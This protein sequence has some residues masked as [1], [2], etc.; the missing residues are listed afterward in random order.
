[1]LIIKRYVKRFLMFLYYLMHKKQKKAVFESFSGKSYSDNPRAISEKLHELLP[2]VEI[3]WLFNDPQ[4]KEKIVPS[5]VRCVKRNTKNMIKEY[6]TAK[7][8]VNNFCMHDFIYK[9]HQNYYIQTWHGDRPF[10]KVIFESEKLNFKKSEVREYKTCDLCVSGSSIGEHVYRKAFLYEGDI[11]KVGSPRADVLIDNSKDKIEKIKHNLNI[12][13][14]SKVVMYAPTFRDTN[15]LNT[16]Q[17]LDVLDFKKLIQCLKDKYENE[18]YCLVRVHPS[19]SIKNNVVKEDKILNVSDYEDMSD[20]LLIS[21][22]LITDYSSSAGDFVLKNKPLILY[23]YDLEEY[24]AEDRELHFRMSDSPFWRVSNERELFD[25]IF[26]L[27]EEDVIKNC[28][29]ILSFYGAY[30]SGKAS[31]SVCKCIEDKIK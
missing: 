27:K 5:Y 20:L 26:N 2:E 8:W 31:E 12:P 29:D 22:L 30:E 1:M 28:R 17:N 19:I 4:K 7:I 16:S 10:K 21:D 24:E 15:G 25:F 23:Q 3:V 13:E 14:N 6:S 9:G 18:W 11:L